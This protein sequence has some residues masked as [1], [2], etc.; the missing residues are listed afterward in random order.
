MYT[1]GWNI[2]SLPLTEEDDEYETWT[3]DKC[4]MVAALSPFER[5][6]HIKMHEKEAET[7]KA[8]RYCFSFRQKRK[9]LIRSF[10]KVYTCIFRNA[11]CLF[12]VL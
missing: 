6:Q 12:I 9:D 8:G 11:W 4:E 1:N 2:F 5:L 3:C 10:T 7:K